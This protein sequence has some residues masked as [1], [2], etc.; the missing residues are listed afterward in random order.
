MCMNFIFHSGESRHLWVMEKW[1]R[2][3]FLAY[4]TCWALESRGKSRSSTLVDRLWFRGL[5][6]HR[7]VTISMTE[8]TWSRAFSRWK[9]AGWCLLLPLHSAQMTWHGTDSPNAEGRVHT[10]PLFC[11]FNTFLHFC[12]FNTYFCF[13]SCLSDPSMA[14]GQVNLH[15]CFNLPGSKLQNLSWDATSP[16]SK[17]FI[18]SCSAR[19]EIR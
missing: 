3:L 4:S 18:Y 1:I 8:S 10:I 17:E 7:T 2:H 12:I 19:P 5:I 15:L 11:I 6:P 16:R 14:V 13:Y 9:V